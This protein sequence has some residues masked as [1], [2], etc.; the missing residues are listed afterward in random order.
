M[1][2]SF[3]KKHTY[4]L[5]GLIV[6]FALFIRVFQLGSMPRGFLEDEAHIGY[7]AYSLLH[8]LR[9]K[10]NVFLP[11]SIDQFGDFRPSGLHFLTIPSVAVFGLT[12]F[13]TRLPVAIFG[14][15]SVLVFYFLA[16]EIFRRRSVALIASSMMAINPWAYSASRTTSESIVALFFVITGTWLLLVYLRRV[17]EKIKVSLLTPILGF[18][19]LL[20]SFQFYHAA[21]YFVPFLVAYLALWVLLEHEYGKRVKAI[22]LT[23]SVLL[24]IGLLSLMR[25]GGGLGR[26]DE[27][28]IFQNPKTQIEIWHQKTE[29]RG[30]P[31]LV[32]QFFHNK[33][34]S[35]GYTA[36]VNYGEHFTPD[37]LFFSGGLPERYQT[38]WSGGFYP[39]EALLMF[40]GLALVFGKIFQ[41]KKI[42]WL[43][44]VPFI[45][46]LAGP[47]PAAFTFEDLPHF[48]RSIM[49]MPALILFSAYG[50]WAIVTRYD[51]KY[52]RYGVITILLMIALYSVVTFAHNYFHHSLTHNAKYRYQGEQQLIQAEDG[53]R[54]QNRPI[55]ATSQGGNHVIFYLFFDK[56]SP[57]YFQSIGSPRD[58]NNLFFDGIKFVTADCPSYDAHNA[59]TPDTYRTIFVDMGS[60]L[61]RSE[62]KLL[63]R[64]YRSD[65]TVAYRVLEIKPELQK[66]AASM[67]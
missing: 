53:Y 54:K 47:L 61:P 37:F 49:M 39:F 43:L 27:I 21:R 36:A 10:N 60:C 30:F 7:N 46:L 12:E 15:L 28:S 35:Y 44:G 16:D 3:I 34:V 9:D 6:V 41:E 55:I 25:L 52:L 13:A 20:I 33:Y 38:P 19:S 2:L 24:A 45:W 1:N 42:L 5:L 4:F 50:L 40:V 31:P 67:K 65:G 32:V 18:V 58:A 22:I 56:M 8:T 23:G 59:V 17:R 29:D 26:V 64:I 14:G 48:Q 51:R 66:Y 62:T 57:Q 11:L 63:Q